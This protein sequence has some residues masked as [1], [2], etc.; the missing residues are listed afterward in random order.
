[1]KLIKSFLAIVLSLSLYTTAFLNFTVRPIY[2][3]QQQD[4]KIAVQRGYRTGYSDGYMSGYRDTIDNAA[5]NYDKH[6]EYGKADR[7]FNKDYG[8][9]EDYR[10]GYRQGFETG[11]DT[12]FEKRSF[13]AT[14]PIDL[15]KRGA[16][17]ITTKPAAVE[18]SRQ[19]TKP[20]ENAT[21][22]ATTAAETTNAAAIEPTQPTNEN[23]AAE[24]TRQAPEIVTTKTAE[25][26]NS[27]A[28]RDD[29]TTLTI[30]T[31]TE[32]IIEMIDDID[33]GRE[34]AGDKFQAR[35]VSPTEINGAVIEGR[36]TKIQ[37][38][39]RIKRRAEMTLSFDRIVLPNNRWSNFNA[40]LTEVLPVRG[41]NVKRVDPEG[42]VQGNRTYKEDS[43]KVGA[44]T[45][46]G[47]VVGAVTGGPV[48]AAVG[49]SVGAAFGVGAVV[50]ERGKEIRI[51]KNQQLRI[52]TAYETQIR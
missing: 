26:Y 27:T 43:V 19:I 34:R 10:D 42:T 51:N 12:G 13:D 36:I 50:I 33:T 35:V 22:N 41:D 8:S 18:E 37:R 31:D 32:L 30:P 2:A 20:S 28:A 39:G 21:A 15:N 11:Y 25:N 48:G 49:A 4:S 16:A 24:P 14:I 45:G 38:P 44:A 17:T 40:I 9:L 7:A 29:E 1:M 6:D 23:V 47:L 52:K 5:K 46:T 3:Q